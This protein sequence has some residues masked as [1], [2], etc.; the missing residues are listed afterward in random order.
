VR[1]ANFLPTAG[2]IEALQGIEKDLVR[3]RRASR[4]GAAVA[5]FAFIVQTIVAAQGPYLANLG[6]FLAN[7]FAGNWD[8]LFGDDGLDVYEAIGLSVVVTGVMVFAGYRWITF[9]F[10]ESEEPF[11]YTF[12][13]EKL[14]ILETEQQFGDRGKGKP[15]AEMER[16]DLLHHDVKER[17]NQRIRRLSLLAPADAEGDKGGNENRSPSNI[18]ILGQCALRHD[19]K[20]TWLHI[21]P[22]VRI[23]PKGTPET[24]AQPIKFIPTSKSKLSASDYGLIVEHVYSSIATEIY[25]QIKTDIEEK[26][27]LFPFGYL[28]AVALVNEAADFERSNTI[29]AYDHAIDLYQ[30]ATRYFTRNKI[31][32]LSRWFAYMPI[33]WRHEIHFAHR[34]ARTFVG[35]ARCLIYRRTVSALSGLRDQ[36][37]LFEIPKFMDDQ[38]DALE[39]LNRHI[40]VDHPYHRSAG[41]PSPDQSHDFLTFLTYPRDN[42]LRILLARPNE[43]LYESQRRLL[44]EAYIVSALTC[45]YLGDI[46]KSHQHLTRATAVA[47][48]ISQESALYFLAAGEVEPEINKKLQHFQKATELDSEFEIAQFQLAY[49]EDM[50]LR[51]EGDLSGFRIKIVTRSYKRVTTINP[52]NVASQLNRGYLHWLAGNLQDA[53]T[54]YREGR[55]KKTIVA[56]TFVGELTYGLARIAAEQDRLERGYELYTQALAADPVVAAYNS[57]NSYGAGSPHFS[58]FNSAMLDRYRSFLRTVS[59]NITR[60]GDNASEESTLSATMLNELHGYVLNDYG[61]ACLN[62]FHRY[63][64]NRCLNEAIDSYEQAR[65]LNPGN[66]VVDFNLYNAY[67]WKNKFATARRRLEQAQELSAAF[68]RVATEFALSTVREQQMNREEQSATVRVE[69]SKFHELEAQLHTVQQEVESKNRVL[70]LMN[71]TSASI[72]DDPRAAQSLKAA[73]KLQVP[74][75]EELDVKKEALKLKIDASRKEVANA[76]YRLLQCERLF[77]QTVNTAVETIVTS[78]KLAPLFEGRKEN[79]TEK[80]KWILKE[81]HRVHWEKFDYDDFDALLALAKVLQHDDAKTALVLCRRIETTFRQPNNFEIASLIHDIE[82]SGKLTSETKSTSSNLRQS[83]RTILATEPAYFSAMVIYVRYFGPQPIE[84]IYQRLPVDY[85]QW[86]DQYHCLL[87]HAYRYLGREMNYSPNRDLVVDYFDQAIAEFRKPL[88][89]DP[90]QPRFHTYVADAYSSKAHYFANT[91]KDSRTAEELRNRALSS[92]QKA[93]ELDKKSAF[94]AV[95]LAIAFAKIEN[96]DKSEYYFNLAIRRDRNNPEFKYKLAEIQQLS[97][98]QEKS[99][100]NYK[101]ASELA[102]WRAYYHAALGRH[103]HDIEK[104]EAAMRSAIMLDPAYYSYYNH[105]GNRLYEVGEYD[106]AVNWYEAAIHRAPD[107]SVLLSNLAGAYEKI[108]GQIVSGQSGDDTSH[109]AESRTRSINITDKAIEALKRAQEIDAKHDSY[110]ERLMDLEKNRRLLSQYA[111]GVLKRIP[112]VTPIALEIAGNLIPRVESSGSE[113]LDPVL[114][115]HVE[116]MRHRILDYYGLRIPG[117]RFRSNEADLPDGTYIIQLMEV[118]LVSGNISLD[119][120]FCP[121]SPDTLEAQK[122]EYLEDGINPLTGGTGSWI[123]EQQWEAVQKAGHPLWAFIEYPVRHLEAVLERNLTDFVGNQE[124][125][126]LVE[127]FTPDKR[128]A[129]LAANGGLP[130]LTGVIRG[131]LAERVP[132]AEF[133]LICNEFLNERETGTDLPEIVEKLRMNQILGKHLQ[134]IGNEAKIYTLANDFEQAIS[135]AL[136]GTG[137]SRVLAM[138]PER[139]QE[140][141]TAVRHAVDQDEHNDQGSQVA[142]LVENSAIRPFLRKLVELEFPELSVLARSEIPDLPKDRIAG[143]VRLN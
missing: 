78:T 84:E 139:C 129:I 95:D 33:L 76:Q 30:S 49:H 46:D 122:I 87:G 110:H 92:C 34:E 21:I 142:L 136:H 109:S 68:P 80:I 108:I 25:R 134:R 82:Q 57:N 71:Q 14:E 115:G 126:N 99:V 77:S 135:E 123:G 65:Y 36:N 24:L 85:Y 88:L 61:N 15:F 107:M 137:E 17:L 39:R 62:Y 93:Q 133:S 72:G 55:E 7:L 118:P 132:I 111:P 74:E 50:R 100:L 69:E 37:T 38:L 117:V 56:A 106:R 5:L 11:R 101:R 10:N 105:L 79:S 104:I 96:Y 130:A 54:V 140:T 124:V 59:D 113:S 114:S 90:D 3:N 143:E 119:R 26:I 141:L 43:S 6:Q 58:Y 121:V 127:Q 19:E 131:L 13:I 47:P 52:G 9:F 86:W 22:T 102:P 40:S 75:I 53:R 44:S 4:L 60:A 16:L 103:S 70:L 73:I 128:D 63:G 18:N 138:M 120:R 12:W 48:V 97:G 64:D 42:W 31:A 28:R 81:H 1:I 94:R 51:M 89:A 29:D 66:L 91:L 27:K 23:G 83:L 98:S 112:V 2:Q 32:K 41:A 8:Q 35:Y 45:H 125:M 20:G 116:G 67:S